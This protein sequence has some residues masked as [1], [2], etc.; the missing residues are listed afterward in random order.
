ML[1]G[2]VQFADGRSEPFDS[3]DPIA[4]LNADSNATVWVDLASPTPEE[5]RS[6][7]ERFALD[8]EAVEDCLSG[9]QRPRVDEFDD[10]I[11]LVVYGAVGVDAPDEFDPRKLAA[12]LGSYYLITVHHESL[13]TVE[14]ARTRCTKFPAQ[15]IGRGADYVLYVLLDGMVDNY[16]RVTDRFEDRLEAIED[17]ALT[18]D[19]D[20]NIP[21]ALSELRREMLSFRRIAASQLELLRP[22]ERGEYPFVA[23]PL[24]RRFAH[25]E[26]HL[27]HVIEVVD[28]LRDRIDGVH[29]IYHAT[30]ATR[31]NNVMKTLTLFAT[32]LLPLS[33]IAGVY[34]MNLPLWPPPESPVSFWLVMG[35]M[36]AVAGAVFVYFRRRK[37]L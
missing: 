16:V 7:A 20:D 23:G 11:F 13:R 37:W 3:L 10:S 31:M 33:F 26:D 5:M 22:L 2:F 30:L 12:F 28:G 1:S 15:L 18:R 17:D 32:L 27:T 9:E 8:A 4:S 14:Y 35:M 36:L 21:A 25:V 6:V 19:P 24:E 34:G 29:D